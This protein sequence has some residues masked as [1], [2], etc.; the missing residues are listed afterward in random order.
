MRSVPFILVLMLALAPG[1]VG[2][3]TSD[4]ES[5]A[6]RP[7]TVEAAAGLTTQFDPVMSAAAGF[8]PFRALTFAVEAERLHVPREVNVYE[9]GFSERPGFTAYMVNGQAR[10]TLPINRR[11][12]AFGMVGLGAGTWD[13]RGPDGGGL[14]Q[15]FLGGGVRAFVR[16]GFSVFASA[17]MGLLVGTDTDSVWGYF[18]IQ[19]GV[20]W[21]F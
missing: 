10:V 12:S 2:A 17:K 18:P 8:S 20:G 11:L 3:Q 1:L 19:G 9:N 6:H 7:W 14:I 5:H 13:R 16:P 21:Q 15:P 4:Q